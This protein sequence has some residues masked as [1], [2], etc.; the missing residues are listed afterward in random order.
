MAGSDWPP[1]PPP[2]RA[3]TPPSSTGRVAAAVYLYTGQFLSKA[4]TAGALAELLG[5]PVSAGTVAAFTGRAA[6]GPHPGWTGSATRS[7]VS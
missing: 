3:W 2:R 5:V 1:A 6:S 4:R 7:A